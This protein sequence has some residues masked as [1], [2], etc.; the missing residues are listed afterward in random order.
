VIRNTPAFAPINAFNV[1][2]SGP[3][4]KEKDEAYGETGRRMSGFRRIVL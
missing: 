1:I 3:G 2:E 4:P